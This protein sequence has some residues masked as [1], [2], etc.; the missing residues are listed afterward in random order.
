MNQ[1]FFRRNRR[2]LFDAA[3]VDAIAMAG[4]ISM[5]RSHDASFAFEQE[6]NFWY[7]TSITYPGWWLIIKK[8]ASY[9]V[10]PDVDEVRRIFDG[11][12]SDDEAKAISGVDVVLQHAEGEKLIKTLKESDMSIATIGEDPRTE[13][14]HFGL[15]PGPVEMVKML[16]STF[17]HVKDI[18]QEMAKIRSIKTPEEIDMIRRAIQLTINGF[19]TVRSNLRNYSYEYEIEADVSY[20]FRKQGA[21]GHAYDPIVA[22]GKNA[23]TLHYVKNQAALVPGEFVLLDVG[24]RYQGYAADITRTYAVGK[25]S[26]RHMA[27]HHEVETAHHKII[28]LLGPGVNVKKY[29]QQVDEIMRAALHNLDLLREKDDYRKYF[30]HSVSH[31]LGIDVHDSLGSPET[32]QPGMILTVEP[33]IYIPEEGIGVRIED[34]ILITQDGYENLSAALPTNM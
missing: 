33:G 30:P 25:V 29:F 28:G 14:Y 27:V 10:A 8:E 11:S 31:G 1:D 4:N 5:Q 9:L 34:D 15:N 2:A 6:A 18:R 7:L 22:A 3:Q 16:R 32:F 17:V 19:E 20:Q 24:A 13:Q 23:C 26:K 12:L 21:I